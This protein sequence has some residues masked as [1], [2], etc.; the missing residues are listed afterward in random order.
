[1]REIAF[2]FVAAIATAQL[3]VRVAHDMRSAQLLAYGE[4]DEAK[5]PSRQWNWPILSLLTVDCTI[6]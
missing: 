3:I 1:M 6:R 4:P 5:G 2:S